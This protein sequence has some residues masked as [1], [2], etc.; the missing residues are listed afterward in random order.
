MRKI[1]L[2]VLA[3]LLCGGMYAEV[4]NEDLRHLLPDIKCPVLLVWGNDDTTTP[5]TDA[6]IMEK[7]IPNAGLVSFPYCG[8]FSFIDNLTNFRAVLKEYLK[9]ELQ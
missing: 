7:L 8:H 9:G 5:L 6:Q 4:L 1:L 2:S 3:I